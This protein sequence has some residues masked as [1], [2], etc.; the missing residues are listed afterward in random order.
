MKKL[1]FAVIIF[2][3]MAGSAIAQDMI[4]AEITNDPKPGQ[5]LVW[6][7]E[8][9]TFT[10]EYYPNPIIEENDPK[11]EVTIHVVY[12]SIPVHEIGDL[13]R[14]QLRKHK[15]A[16]KVEV[17]IRNP[18]DTLQGVS[19]GG[20]WTNL[21]TDDVIQILTDEDTTSD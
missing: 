7:P 17:K 14:D 5:Q 15:D 6:H 3:L 18:E 10:W 8:N 1:L 12:N 21:S 9:H 13:V 16:C 19:Y 2:M 11:Y 4:T 20:T